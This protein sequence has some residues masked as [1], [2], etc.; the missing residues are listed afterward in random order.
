MA[1]SPREIHST[2]FPRHSSSLPTIRFRPE[3]MLF[4]DQKLRFNS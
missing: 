3:E 2:E 1:A 4:Y